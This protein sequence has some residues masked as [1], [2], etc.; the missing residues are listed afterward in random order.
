VV[1]GN[2]RAT[3]GLLEAA[4]E[5]GPHVPLLLACSGEEYGPVPSGRLPVDEDQ[6]L[7]PQNPYAVSKASADLLGGFFA[8]A[9]GLRIVRTRAFNHIGPGQGPAYV[10]ASLARQIAEAERS[11]A[12]GSTVVISTGNAE[13][14]RDFTDVRDVV[15]AYWAALAHADTGV[16]NVCSSRA[17]SI[18]EILE[19]IARHSPLEVVQRTDPERVRPHDVPEVR[20]SHARLTEATGW[21]PRI[22]LDETLGDTLEWW[23]GQR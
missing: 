12:D 18:L 6:P 2:I 23:R 20:G 4:R 10:V 21:T 11:R 3:L 8:D 22:P 13:V 15:R 1:E 9:H 16:Y 7:R 14:R 5:C 19:G 17:V